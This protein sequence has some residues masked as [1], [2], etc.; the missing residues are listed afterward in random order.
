MAEPII[1]VRNLSKAYRIWQTPSA[2]LKSP[3]FEGAAKLF[4]K[5]SAPHRS[6]SARAAAGYRD[7]YALRDLSFTVRRGEAT[8]IIGRNG[9]GKS[10][11]LQLIAGTLTPTTGTL[12]V[13]GRV[14]A[15]LEL[16]SGFNPDFTGRENVFLNGAI[17]GLSHAEMEGKF[18]EIAAFADIGDFI[19]QP[20]KTYSSGMMVRLAFSVG[21]S[22][23]PDILI[24]DEALSV[25][26]VFFQQKCFKKLHD[27]LE[28]GTT[29]LFVSHDMEAVRNLCEQVVLLNEGR[30]D[31]VGAPDET[32]SRYY[33]LFGRRVEG[34]GAPGTPAAAATVAAEAKSVLVTHDLLPAAKS[35]HGDRSLEIAALAVENEH[36]ANSL[37]V[38]MT[39][40][41]T[42]RILLRAQEA[43]SE[44]SL[45]LN[46]YDR[47][48]NLVFAAGTRQLGVK[49]PPMA[50]GEE[51]IVTFK[52]TCNLQPGEYTFSVEASEPS[53]EGPNFGFL[54]DKHEGLGP[55]AVHYEHNHTW[56]FYGIARLPLEISV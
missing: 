30:M 7:F 14:S 21:F 51:R 13:N 6:L 32:V 55:L 19:D 40:V 20:V 8:G 28:H 1:E 24:I 33:A 37:R 26:D 39:R 12:D 2:R 46:V 34:A 5:S 56:P 54:H 42:L 50:A 52:L 41:A 23:Q 27:M 44:P 31:F 10:T 35:R 16:G 29:L 22:V 38:E 47:M 3:F 17:F 25:G 49:L 45:G 9:S 48:A 18:D 53:T 4:G 43:V 11:L 15:L 36:G